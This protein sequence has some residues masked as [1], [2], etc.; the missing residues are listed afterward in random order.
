MSGTW[1]EQD[2]DFEKRR[3]QTVGGT[4]FVDFAADTTHKGD[5]SRLGL[6]LAWNSGP[7][8]LKTEWLWLWLDD[9]RG[10]TSRGNFDFFAGY[11]SV[12]Y[13][14]TGEKKHLGQTAPDRPFKPGTDDWG[15]LE[16][17][18][19]YSLFDSKD[20]LFDRGLAIGTS[21]ADAFTIALNWYLNELARITMHYE[22]TEFD[23]G[24]IVGNE[25]ADDEDV[26]LLQCQL[27]F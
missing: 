14:L 23:E 1:G 22:H 13:L 16:V 4:D 6:E 25:T 9:L 2:A 3:F 18:A 5:R 24:I 7:A 26:F 8:S 27:E 11:L 15:A 19:R 20:S 12:S 21:R 17:A 10:P